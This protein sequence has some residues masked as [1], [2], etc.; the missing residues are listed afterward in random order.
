VEVRRHGLWLL[1]KTVSLFLLLVVLFLA[2]SE[3]LCDKL[4]SH[5]YSLL[6]R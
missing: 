6:I 5:V 1:A 2:V 4:F 3:D